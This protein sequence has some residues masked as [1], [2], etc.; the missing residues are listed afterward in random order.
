MKKLDFMVEDRESNRMFDK[1]NRHSFSLRK[2]ITKPMRKLAVGTMSAVFSAADYTSEKLSYAREGVEDMV[3]EAQY[4]SKRRRANM[5]S[6]ME[7]SGQC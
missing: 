6:D 4:N 1:V 7:P 2:M 5:M 3:A